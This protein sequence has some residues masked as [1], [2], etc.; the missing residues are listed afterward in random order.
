MINNELDLLDMRL[1][2]LGDIVEKFVIVES[3]RTHSGN[4]KDLNF[5]TED[6][7]PNRYQRNKLKI[8][9]KIIFIFH[10]VSWCWVDNTSK[11]EPYMAWGNE[12]SQRNM[13]L[14]ALSTQKPKDGLLMVSDIDEIPDSEKLKSA[15]YTYNQLEKKIPIML[16]MTHCL[17]FMNMASD[18]ISYG[19]YLYDPSLSKEDPTTMRWHC[20]SE[21]RKDFVQIENA[22]WHF[23]TLG[24]IE[25]IRN[26]IA[27][28]AHTEFNTSEITSE[29]H[30]SKCINE[31]IPFWE[32]LFKF[33]NK[34][35]RFSKK[36][37]S[38]LPKYVQD[39]MWKFG[40]YILR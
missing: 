4:K 35:I 25:D 37:I 34:E 32:T 38:F 13:I 31:G 5:F 22:G 6:G 39:N 30:L 19:P 24:K 29:E 7:Q 28:F 12:S 18:S 17:Y 23:S 40:K 11:R 10:D 33:D 36:E 8:L 3:N 2:M 21:Y 14:E 9:D 16:N 15:L 1:N 26:K 27:S 20:C